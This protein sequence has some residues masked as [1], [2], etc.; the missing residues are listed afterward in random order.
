MKSTANERPSITL[1]V[2]EIHHWLK[3]YAEGG[4]TNLQDLAGLE[5]FPTLRVKQLS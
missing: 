2:T 3:Q 1:S 5:I 4:R